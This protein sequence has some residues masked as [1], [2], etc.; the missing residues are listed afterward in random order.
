[1]LKLFLGNCL[2]LPWGRQEFTAELLTLFRAP[3]QTASNFAPKASLL[4]P[5]SSCLSDCSS[6]AVLS[7]E[8]P[9]PSP[10]LPVSCAGAMPRRSSAALLTFAKDLSSASFLC[11]SLD[12]IK[13]RSSMLQVNPLIWRY[14]VKSLL[15]HPMRKAMVSAP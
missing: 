10:N 5:R 15:K 11:A 6:F 12:A 3:V 8:G 4:C 14:F 13:D 9:P 2:V 7:G 1:M